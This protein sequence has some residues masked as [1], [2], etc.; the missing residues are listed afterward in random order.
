[1]KRI[2]LFAIVVLLLAACTPGV[3]G[4]DL[5]GEWK[6]VSYGDA[7]N[8]TRALPDVETTIT[9]T[10]GQMGGNVGCNSFGGEYRISGKTITFEPIMSTEMYC[11]KTA[12]QEQG[13][14]SRLQGKM[15]FTLTG[16]LLTLVA[17]DGS[18]VNLARKATG[19]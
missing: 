8:P 13:V 9:F 5:S 10:K 1:M 16:D 15:T 17:A 2:T 4:T 11:E 7:A 18:V 6:L 14:L 19:Y 12:D 3:P